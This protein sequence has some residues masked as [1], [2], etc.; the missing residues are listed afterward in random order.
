MELYLH[1]QEVLDQ[2]KPRLGLFHAPGL[3]KTITLLEL[4]KKNN[5]QTLIICPKG[6]KK[7]WKEYVKK[8]EA[9]HVVYTKEEFRK[10]HKELPRYAAVITDE[11]HH[12]SNLKSGLT[13]SLLW[14]LK[15]HNVHYRWLATGTPYRSS[16]MNIY[17]L[18]K[19]LGYEWDYW[20]FF[21]KFF[22]MVNMGQRQVPVAIKGMEEELEKYVHEIG[23]TLALDA[24]MDVPEQHYVTEIIELT[25]SQK[26]IIKKLE[27]PI[28]IVRNTRIHCIEQGFSYG[29]EYLNDEIFESNKTKRVI[30][31]C[32]EFKTIAIVCRYTLQIELL[33]Q[34]LQK[35][36]PGRN[37]FV[38]SGSTKD[39]HDVVNQIN[40]SIDCIV[41]I[42]SQCSEGYEMAKVQAMVFASLDW[43]FL[44]Y[45]Q[46]KARILRMNAL[47]E[48]YYYHLVSPGIDKQ[49]Y[50][51]IMQHRDF[52]LALCTYER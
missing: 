2:N 3:G 18:G 35:E 32:K 46:M 34:S 1:Q 30:N 36:F 45:E 8:Y 29:N 20:R 13:K 4:A 51:T 27:E 9:D 21:S 28:P 47:K 31:L 26:E 16:A 37:I 7:Q 39:R 11:C 19:L 33:N 24:V 48:N 41:L 40:A 52:H 23:V 22:K 44:N 5:V 42:Q 12:F 14:Y 49:I 50:E 38:I 43:A 25:D 17:A 15:A 10:Y 6:I